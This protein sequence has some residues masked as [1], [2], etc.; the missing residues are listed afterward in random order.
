MTISHAGTGGETGDA[1]ETRADARK[2]AVLNMHARTVRIASSR[3][4]RS[5]ARAAGSKAK[6]QLDNIS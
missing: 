3:I 2:T 4:P 1:T 6:R 5:R